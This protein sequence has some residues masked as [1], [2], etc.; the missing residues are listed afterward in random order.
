MANQAHDVPKIQA[1]LEARQ[2]L[3]AQGPQL[4]VAQRDELRTKAGGDDVLLLL[5]ERYAPL[6]LAGILGAGIMAA[7]MA[8]DSQILALSTLF[9]EDIF[10]F[11]GGKSR[12]GE[13]V[14]VQTGR[15]FVILLTI[16]A[17]GIALWVPGNIFDAAVQYGFTGYAALSPLLIAAL[18]WSGS[19][20]W[21]A[22]AST[23]WTVAGMAAIAVFQALVP[24]PL[25]GPPVV[26]L[27][28]AGLDVISRTPGGTAIF[29]LMPVVP[30]TLISALLMVVVSC[31]TTKPSTSTIAAYF[32]AD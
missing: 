24:A 23:L 4:T 22:L 21:G 1:K 28:V 26:V 12:F 6:W 15:L 3:A 27:T 8:S 19:T 20:Q 10:A 29:G 11:Y 18:F 5:L 2:T 16:I 25:A 32:P 30:L 31:C 17:Y 13:A 7:V 14:Q 9:T